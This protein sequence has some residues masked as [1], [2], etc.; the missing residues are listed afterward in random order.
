MPECNAYKF[1]CHATEMYGNSCNV[2]IFQPSDLC[3]EKNDLIGRSE[4]L[5][6]SATSN[7]SRYSIFIFFRNAARFCSTA[8]T[9]DILVCAL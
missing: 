3:P 9:K 6:D 2:T 7:V 1:S 8:R 4:L 5:I